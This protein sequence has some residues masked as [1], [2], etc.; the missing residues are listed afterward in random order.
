MKTM[1][2]LLNSQ[3]FSESDYARPWIKAIK[4]DGIKSIKETPTLPQN[5]NRDQTANWK[6]KLSHVT[7]CGCFQ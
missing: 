5:E 2:R 3:L 7:N 6:D 4:E 1:C